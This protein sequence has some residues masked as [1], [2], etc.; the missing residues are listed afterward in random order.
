MVKEAI[1]FR[2]EVEAGYAVRLAHKN[3][4]SG[5]LTGGFMHFPPGCNAVVQVRLLVSSPTAGQERQIIPIQDEYIALD[6]SQWEFEL[7]EIV[8]K[9]DDIL[10]DIRNTGA[11]DHK[12]SVVV[13]RYSGDPTQAELEKESQKRKAEKQRGS[14]Q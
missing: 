4:K 11:A 2:T 9:G 3:K 7:D 1:N 8:L 5:K 14:H 10:V 13:T 6:D 12:I